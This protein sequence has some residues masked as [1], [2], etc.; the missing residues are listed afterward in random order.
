ME[1]ALASLTA[2]GSIDYLLSN[3]EQKALHEAHAKNP[4][5]VKSSALTP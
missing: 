1:Q 3:A 4:L 5:N 2:A